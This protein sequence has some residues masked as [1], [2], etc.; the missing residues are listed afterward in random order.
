MVAYLAFVIA[1]FKDFSPY[2]PMAT[3][4]DVLACPSAPPPTHLNTEG[5]IHKSKEYPC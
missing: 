1:F 3:L 4:L 5:G 2:E